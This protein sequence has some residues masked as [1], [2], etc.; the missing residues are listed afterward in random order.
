M[1]IKNIRE[2]IKEYFLVNPTSKL[3]VRRIEKELKL[4]LPSVI[5]YCKELEKEGILMKIKIGNVVFYTANRVSGTFLLEKKLFNIKSLYSCRLI[6]F[7]K[8][9]LNNPAIIV[10]GSY[11]KGEDLENSD[12]DLY[13][14][15]PSKRE[16]NLE[17]FKKVLKRDIQIFRHKS[18][19]EIKNIHLSNNILNGVN[20][21]GFVEVFK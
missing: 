8:E 5:R 19:S 10:F 16:I 6:D 14:E 3:R 4:S 21:N 7:L 15:T 13:V 9:E 1:K 11:A 20:L 2:R 12:V 17:K 18:I